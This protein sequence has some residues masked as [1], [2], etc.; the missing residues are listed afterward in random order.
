VARDVIE[1]LELNFSKMKISTGNEHVFLGMKITY[2]F[3]KGNFDIDMSSYLQQT[4]EEFGEEILEVS[5][6]T[7]ADLFFIDESK[8]LVDEKK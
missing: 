8:S 1:L 7:W 3:D 6:P 4:V 2:Y 5:M